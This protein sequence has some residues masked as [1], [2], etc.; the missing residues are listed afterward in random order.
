MYNKKVFARNLGKIL[1]EKKLT[2]KEFSEKIGVNKSSISL[3][4]Q[5]ANMPSEKVVD[6]IVEVLEIPKELLFEEEV[7]EKNEHEEL[8]MSVKEAAEKL[9]KSQIFIQYSLRAGT[10]PYGFAVKLSS[11]WTYCISR[12]KFNEFFGL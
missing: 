9:N 4:L 6:K 11:Q 12:A 8:T 2:Q 3:Y 5:G 1:L 10:A 7:K